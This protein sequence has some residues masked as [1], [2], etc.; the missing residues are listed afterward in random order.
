MSSIRM[1]PCGHIDVRIL[2]NEDDYMICNHGK[3]YFKNLPY[4]L[5]MTCDYSAYTRLV[6]DLAF[7]Y[8]QLDK[9]Y[10]AYGSHG[11]DGQGWDFEEY[12]EIVN[13]M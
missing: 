7:D 4:L 13:W 12:L 9:A 3:I 11:P 1:L 5:C 6:K 10:L 8:D 2:E